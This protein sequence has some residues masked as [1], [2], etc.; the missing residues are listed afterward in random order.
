[1]FLV[2][3]TIE[4]AT[5]YRD[6]LV[7]S[8]M[9]GSSEAVLLV[10]SEEPDATLAAAGSAGGPDSPVRAVV[11]VSMLKEGWDVKNIYVI[12]SVRSMESSC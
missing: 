6:L 8:D 10:T 12:A 7:G 2:A 5:E 11:S 1:M 4:E 9:L 3:T